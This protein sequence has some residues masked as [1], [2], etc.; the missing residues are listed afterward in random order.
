[1]GARRERAAERPTA[2]RSGEHRSVCTATVT[3]PIATGRV[4]DHDRGSDDATDEPSGTK[5]RNE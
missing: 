2:G 3:A 5:Y 4:T 1:M